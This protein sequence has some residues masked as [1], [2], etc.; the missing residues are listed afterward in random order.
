MGQGF[1]MDPRMRSFETR[2]AA[3]LDDVAVPTG[4]Q[5]RLMARLRQPA[6]AANC[7]SAAE[8]QA[9][10]DSVTLPLP[11]TPLQRHNASLRRWLLAGAALAA[12]LLVT[13]QFFGR[14]DDSKTDTV[15]LAAAWYGQLSPQWK[16]MQSVPAG[17]GMPG[18]VAVRAQSWQMVSRIAGHPAVAFNLS[19][20]G[21]K[22]SVL[23]AVK[24]TAPQLPGSP[25]GTPSSTTN[26]GQTIAAWQNAGF[27][28]VLVVE[29]DEREYRRLINSTAVRV[30]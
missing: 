5:E 4:L 11:T 9:V 13:W 1:V 24:M 21:F 23:F 10:P 22:R 14:T 15:T 26:G 30:A 7:S 8:I 18:G 16:P 28:Y 12:S 19:R 27:V 3:A 6:D 2:L 17:F 25:P 20:P 29:G